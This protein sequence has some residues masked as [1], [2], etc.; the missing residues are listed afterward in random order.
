MKSDAAASIF[1]Y[2][3][4]RW[5]PVA[6]SHCA[7]GVALPIVIAL[8][9]H[10]PGTGV[11]GGLGALYTGI[12]SNGGANQPRSKMMIG[13]C[14]ATSTATFLGVLLGKSHPMAAIAAFLCAFATATLGV[15]SQLAS[16]LGLQ[17]TAVLVVFFGDRT[18]S[19]NGPRE[20]LNRFW[21]SGGST[22]VAHF[23]L[24]H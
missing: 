4:S 14:V 9:I 21:R 20:R 13:S 22:F 6:A 16:T 12:A 5:N 1:A 2:D 10:Q 8:A 3:K 23:C 11:L 7:V 15:S 24:A 18:T 17:A 19:F